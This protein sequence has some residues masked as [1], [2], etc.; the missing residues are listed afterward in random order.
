MISKDEFIKRIKNLKSF[1]STNGTAS[2]SNLKLNGNQLSFI[3]DN[4]DK[5]WSLNVEEVYAVYLKEHRFNTMV[6]R[7]Y[8]KGRVFSPSLGL[9]IATGLCDANGNRNTGK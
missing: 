7:K 8:L 1:T 2:Y 3:R 6:L 5:V 9:L 4:T